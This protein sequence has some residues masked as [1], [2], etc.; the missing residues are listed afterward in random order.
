MVVFLLFISLILSSCTATIE[1]KKNSQPSDITVIGG[2]IAKDI[3]LNGK[4]KIE[5]D[6]LIASGSHVEIEEGSAILVEKSDISRTEPVFL[7][8]ETEIVVEGRLTV[9]GTKE[10]PVI[11]TSLDKTGINWGGIIVNKGVL[12]AENMEINNAYNAINLINGNV[13]L[14]DSKF[15]GN[16][17]GISVLGN[18]GSAEISD[19]YFSKN[20][21]AI[22]NNSE[23][24]NFSNV[25]V[26]KNDE[27]VLLRRCP[28]NI[29]NLVVRDN[30]YGIVMS[31]QC[32]DFNLIK[33]KSYENKKDNIIFADFTNQ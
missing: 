4:V 17:I 23:R 1:E 11:F 3:K 33:I 14:K 10:K 5:K 9:K 21:N 29:E 16:K 8:P 31:N 27:G 12:K 7:M 20:E 30:L 32:I 22:I 6:L 2:I 28:H 25:I 13:Y 26:E 19:A 24:T 15:V 18:G